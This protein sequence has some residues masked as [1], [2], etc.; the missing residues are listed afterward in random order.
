MRV[1]ILTS[2]KKSEE[3]YRTM[4]SQALAEKKKSIQNAE[5]EADNLV[6]KAQE[7]AEEYRKQKNCRNA[8]ICIRTACA[9]GENR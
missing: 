3:E 8:E 7:S 1:E 5:L 2:I 9:R 6:M 4:I